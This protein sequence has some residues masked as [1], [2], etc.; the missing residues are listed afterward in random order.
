MEQVDEKR[1]LQKIQAITGGIGCDLVTGTSEF[2]ARKGRIYCAISNQNF[3]RIASYKEDRTPGGTPTT[4]STSSYIAAD[5]NDN[6]FIM[7]DYPLTHI[8]LSAGSI[9]VYYVMDFK[10]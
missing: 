3:S 10:E 4:V 2:K 9:W 1:L 6:K 5:F 7:F 8:T